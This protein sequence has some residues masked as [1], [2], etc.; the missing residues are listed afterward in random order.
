LIEVNIQGIRVLREIGYDGD[1]C[2]KLAAGG[3][4]L[5]DYVTIVIFSS[6]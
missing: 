3:A 1:R 2:L 4:E 5:S 6:T